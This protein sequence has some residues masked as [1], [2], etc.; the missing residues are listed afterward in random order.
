MWRNGLAMINK[1]AD[2]PDNHGSITM[3]SHQEAIWT[4]FQNEGGGVFA[5]SRTRLS[6]LIGETK[7]RRSQ[8]ILNIGVGGGYFEEIA[9]GDGLNIASLDP[10]P[11]AIKSL[12]ERL[13]IDARVG[14]I[15]QAPFEDA[16]FDAVVVSEVLE[17]LDYE[18]ML[19]GLREVKRVLVPGGYVIGT[20]PYQE[21]LTSNMAVCPYCGKLFHRWGHLQ[22]FSVEAIQEVLTLLYEVEHVFPRLFLSFSTLNW[23]GKL[24]GLAKLILWKLGMRGSGGQIVFIARKASK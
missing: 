15:Q 4:Y 2:H 5:G 18:T 8:R 10:D 1:P 11:E 6:Y 19:Q 21:D 3:M 9:L 16:S 24:L 14:W 17:H 23:K 20:V 13:G 12:S 22:S 7:K